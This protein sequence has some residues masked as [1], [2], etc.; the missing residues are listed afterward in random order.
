MISLPGPCEV[1]GEEATFGTGPVRGQESLL[2][3]EHMRELIEED[4]EC[5]KG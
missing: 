5:L 3:S 2:C 4:I 1:C